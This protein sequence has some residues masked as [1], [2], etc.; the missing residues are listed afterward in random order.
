MHVRLL[1]SAWTLL[2]PLGEKL[3]A[4]LLAWLRWF[5]RLSVGGKVAASAVEILVLYVLASRL[6]TSVQTR[7]ELVD[8]GSLGLAFLLV[9]GV[10]LSATRSR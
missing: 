9:F 10:L 1:E 7:R 6:P 8:G 3:I 4:L 2:H 5:W